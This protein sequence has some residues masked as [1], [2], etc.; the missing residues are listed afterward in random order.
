[1][2]TQLTY[3]LCFKYIV[4]PVKHLFQQSRDGYLKESNGIK[5][6]RQTGKC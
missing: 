3:L 2:M 5:V 6:T 1:M 4:I